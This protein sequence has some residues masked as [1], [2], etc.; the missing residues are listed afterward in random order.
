MRNYKLFL[1]G[2]AIISV[3]H[4]NRAWAEDTTL[5]V[6]AV[7]QIAASIS[8]TVD[9]DF[10]TIIADPAGDTIRIDATNASGG[11]T[12]TAAT[13]ATATAITNGSTVTVS[14][15]GRIDVATAVA[16]VDISIVFPSGDSTTL[17]N[18]TGD[19][20]TVSNISTYSSQNF[21]TVAANTYYVHIGGD[22]AVGVAQPAGTYTG[23]ID[24]TLNY[25]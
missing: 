7:V 11:L 22:L 9:L 19:T 12:N 16:A 13:P 14:N 1:I 10:G 2:F 24:I 17:T 4:F 20:M 3:F 6:N 25:N 18:G 15:S 21:Q 23:T 8:N 5:N